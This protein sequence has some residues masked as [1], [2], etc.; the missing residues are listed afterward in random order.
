MSHQNRKKILYFQQASCF[1]ATEGYIRTLAE[2][3]KDR[4]NVAIMY[5]DLPDLKLFESISGV[6]YLPLDSRRFLG[7]LIYNIRPIIR[8]IRLFSPDIVH[9]NDPSP[10]GIIA[11]RLAGVASIVVT[12][13]TPELNIQ[14]GWK[15]TIA[16]KIAF[17]MVDHFIF[18]SPHDQDTGMEKDNIQRRKTSVIAYG[19]DPTR[20]D[21]GEDERSAARQKIRTKF[22]IPKDGI[23][24][25]S[26]ARLE[27]Q[28]SQSDL[29]EAANIIS[30]KRN[31]VRFMIIGEGSLRSELEAQIAEEALENI[32][33]LPGFTNN[34]TEFL[35]AVD[36]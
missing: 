22:N 28:K 20:F 16:R 2:G 23:V 29:I 33:L 18:T 7:N 9:C 31:D 19:L 14:Y 36:I 12:Y 30:S 27:P 25:G 11:S 5:P 10:I 15:G 8:A 26:M 13:H 1:G 4:F 24:I 35:C 34:T 17:N 32:F 21:L 6:M 3:L